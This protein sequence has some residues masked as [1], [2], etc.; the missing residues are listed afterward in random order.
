MKFRAKNYS[1]SVIDSVSSLMENSFLERVT[2]GAADRAAK[3]VAG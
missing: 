3:N 1:F 2:I